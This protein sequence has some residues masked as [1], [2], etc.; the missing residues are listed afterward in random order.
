MTME[1]INRDKNLSY[2]FDSSWIYYFFFW[3][4]WPNKW[5]FILLLFR[6]LIWSEEKSNKNEP[7]E[8]N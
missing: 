6:L 2:W 4:G 1:M 3:L 5:H 8:R 7:N